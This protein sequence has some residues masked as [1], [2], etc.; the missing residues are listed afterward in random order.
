VTAQPPPLDELDPADWGPAPSDAQVAAATQANLVLIRQ[1]E[2]Q[3][4][5]GCVSPE[6]A[7]DLGPTTIDRLRDLIARGDLAT[8]DTDPGL[9]PP[10]NSSPASRT[11]CCLGW[12]NSAG[13]SQAIR[14]R[15][16]AG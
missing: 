13:C 8:L 11:A 1:H 6:T 10:G 7:A 16:P 12:P 4:R 5:A 15:S 3:L 2:R 14:L 9:I